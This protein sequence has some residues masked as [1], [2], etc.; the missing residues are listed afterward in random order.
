[1]ADFIQHEYPG[2]RV[3]MAGNG[4]EALAIVESVERA[5]CLI[6]LDLMMPVNERTGLLEHGTGELTIPS[7][8]FRSP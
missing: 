8:R 1:M 5:P 2:Y 4:Q 3:H 7:R 6:L